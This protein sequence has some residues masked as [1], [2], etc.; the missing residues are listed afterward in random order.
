MFRDT[1]VTYPD[2]AMVLGRDLGP[3]IDVGPAMTRKVLKANGQVV[4]RSTVRSLTPDEIADPTAKEARDQFTE[5]VNKILGDCFKYEDF[6]T[7]PELESFETPIYEK[8]D[9]DVDGESPEIPDEPDDDVDTHDQ[10]VGAEV[11]LPI[12]GKMMNAK[13]RGRKRLSDGS[14]V[15][16][17]NPNPILDTRTYEV[18]FPDGQTAEMAANVI[19]QNMYAMCDE[20]GN[21]FLLLAGIL[22]HRKDDNAIARADMYVKRDRMSTSVSPLGD[23]NCVWNGETGVPLG[24]GLPIEKSRIQ[25]RWRTMPSQR[26][27]IRSPLL[28]GGSLLRFVAGTVLSLL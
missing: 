24:R 12:G 20:E 28:L 22:D 14:V 1:S 19:A 25:S 4:Y 2:D 26:V 17:A 8:Y 15:G 16:R 27:S 11:I 3:A 6:A 10:Y 23:G 7:D 18:E 13:V 9:D 21:Q 5:S